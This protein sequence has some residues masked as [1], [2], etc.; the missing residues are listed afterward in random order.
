[1]GKFLL[2]FL[3]CFFL[4]YLIII[5][6]AIATFLL[7]LFLTQLQRWSISLS[8]YLISEELIWD[9]SSGLETLKE[10][11]DDFLSRLERKIHLA[12][13]KLSPLHR[14]KIIYLIKVRELM[15]RFLFEEWMNKGSPKEITLDMIIPKNTGFPLVVGLTFRIKMADGQFIDPGRDINYKI[16]ETGTIA[17]Y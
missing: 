10:R 12:L 4:I 5:F 17:A 14:E 8:S 9:T 1:M 7:A 2:L 16:T 6:I 11:F 15:F 3:F 13:K